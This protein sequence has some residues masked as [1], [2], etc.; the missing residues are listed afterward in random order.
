M[1]LLHSDNIR[2]V[3]ILGRFLEHHRVFR[4]GNGEPVLPLMWLES[5]RDTTKVTL[6]RYLKSA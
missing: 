4:F 3:S 1:M 6:S 2:V 5:L